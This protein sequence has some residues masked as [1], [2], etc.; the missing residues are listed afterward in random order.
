MS[1]E[2]LR[3]IALR[4]IE[5]RYH[6]FCSEFEVIIDKNENSIAVEGKNT[7]VAKA[8]VKINDNFQRIE[9]WR[10]NIEKKTVIYRFDC[11][12]MIE[13]GIGDVNPIPS[14]HAYLGR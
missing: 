5:A 6:N 11:Y 1:F 2:E 4:A 3:E 7:I 8:S 10:I 13:D 9:F 14:I 12:K